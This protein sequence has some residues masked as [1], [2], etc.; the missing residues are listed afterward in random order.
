M[1]HSPGEVRAGEIRELDSSFE[2]SAGTGGDSG[3]EMPGAL[4]VSDNRL[5][6]GRR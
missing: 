5:K 2:T 4:D 1:V 3:M 6:R